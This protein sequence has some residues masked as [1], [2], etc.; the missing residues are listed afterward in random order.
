MQSHILWLSLC[1]VAVTCAATPSQASIVNPTGLS[2]LILWLDSETGV[3]ADANG[4]ATWADQSGSSNNLSQAVNGRKASIA[5]GVTPTGR[6]AI[7][8]VTG[9]D[10]SDF[11]LSN[12]ADLQLDATF[13]AF[14]VISPDVLP[15]NANQRFA[16]NYSQGKFRFNNGKAS[17]HAGVDADLNSPL[18]QANQFQTIVYR[19]DSNVQIGIDSDFDGNVSLTTTSNSSNTS[20]S[21]FVLG[22]VPNSH[23][24]GAFGSFDG[25]IAAVVI[26]DRTLT[27]NEVNMVS[28]YLNEEFISGAHVVPEP[29]S[30]IILAGAILCVA[31]CAYVRR[32][33]RPRRQHP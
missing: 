20:S 24:G 29:S 6:N 22:G 14:F 32:R 17:M 25:D 19:R 7:S 5:V 2:D 30:G 1:G 16:G 12:A 21:A 28:G 31:G 23:T 9:G 26:Y 15:S 18:P 27:D 4:V 3:S 10:G 11:L 8:F 13:T 33:R